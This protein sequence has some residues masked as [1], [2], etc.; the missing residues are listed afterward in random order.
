MR[1]FSDKLYN[2]S[3]LSLKNQTVNKLCF[4]LKQLY[5]EMCSPERWDLCRVAFCVVVVVIVV[6]N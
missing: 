5:T 1:K 4:K 6:G 3:E 2:S